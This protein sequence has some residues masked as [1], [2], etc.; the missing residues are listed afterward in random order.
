MTSRFSHR[1]VGLDKRTLLARINLLPKTQ[2]SRVEKVKPIFSVIARAS[3]ETDAGASWQAPSL[4]TSDEPVSAKIGYPQQNAYLER[5]N[6]A[7]KY[8]WL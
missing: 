6:R 7:A 5:H 2:E 3:A 4:S 8:N 1:A